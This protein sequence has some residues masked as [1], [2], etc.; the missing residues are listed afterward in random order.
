MRSIRLETKGCTTEV[1]A[2][3]KQRKGE[4]ECGQEKEKEREK[5]GRR[6]RVFLDIK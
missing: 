5:S 1:K 4:R 2:E 6:S 3:D